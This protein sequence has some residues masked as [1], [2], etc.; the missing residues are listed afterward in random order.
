MTGT[1]PACPCHNLGLGQWVAP[2]DGT[3]RGEGLGVPGPGQ[4]GW[5]T[6]TF[7]LGSSLR[8]VLPEVLPGS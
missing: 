3:G 4:P 7:S 1:E 5:D 8:L 2:W 6:L